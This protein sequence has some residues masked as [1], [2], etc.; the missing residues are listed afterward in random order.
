MREKYAVSTH[1]QGEPGEGRLA[2][3]EGIIPSAVERTM[4]KGFMPSAEERTM[5]EGFIPSAV[6]RTMVGAFMPSAVERTMADG[7]TE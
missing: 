2:E 7:G 1:S 4:V 3:W 5:A 6:E